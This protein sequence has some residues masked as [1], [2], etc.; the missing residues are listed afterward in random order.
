MNAPR[1]HWTPEHLAMLRTHYPSLHTTELAERLGVTLKQVYAKANRMGLRKGP[2]FLASSKSGHILKG[3]SL[4]QQHQ[5]TPGQTPWNKGRSYQ[6]GGRSVHTQFQKGNQ[7]HTT[8]P[9]GAYRVVTDKS[10][11]QHMEQKT[12]TTSGTNNLRWTP[13]ARLVWQAVHGPLPAGHIVVFKPGERTTVLENITPDR[14]ECIS[15]KQNAQRNHPSSSNPELGRLIQLKG[16]ITRQVNR[17]YRESD[18]S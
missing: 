4:S 7:P 5:F 15:R 10:G 9:L 13:V 2:A 8:L 16:A 17:I 12:G 6:A 3:G 14:L 18:A 11:H 1:H